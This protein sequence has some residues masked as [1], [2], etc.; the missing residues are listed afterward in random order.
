MVACIYCNIALTLLHVQEATM[1]LRIILDAHAVTI[2]Y[3]HTEHATYIYSHKY[4][5]IHVFA[6]LSTRGTYLRMYKYF[7]VV[8]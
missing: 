7:L 6:T 5:Y 4:Y 2:N 8:A 3:W 1:L